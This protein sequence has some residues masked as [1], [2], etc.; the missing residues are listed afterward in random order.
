MS[1]ILFF[2]LL[3]F[4]IYLFIKKQN[5]LPQ[6]TSQR[7]SSP[8]VAEDMVKCVHCG[9]NMPRSEAIFSKGEF[10][11]TPEHMRLRQK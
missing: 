7:P 5:Q 2:A 4:A 6:Q 10:F 9:V 1:K 11:C 8:P 3:G